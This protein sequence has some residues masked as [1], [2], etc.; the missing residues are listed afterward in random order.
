MIASRLL[1]IALTQRKWCVIHHLNSIWG[2]QNHRHSSH[3]CCVWTGQDKYFVTVLFL[4]CFLFWT[5]FQEKNGCTFA[6]AAPVSHLL[7]RAFFTLSGR[8]IDWKD[9]WAAATSVCIMWNKHVRF[10]KTE[11]IISV[12]SNIPTTSVV[13]PGVSRTAE[14]HGQIL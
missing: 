7:M 3:G 12:Q 4:E 11:Q 8:K 13:A 6:T 10:L 14:P 1:L 2:W 9:I 5:S